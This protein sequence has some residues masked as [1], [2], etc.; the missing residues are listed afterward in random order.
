MAT[1]ATPSAAL[2]VKVSNKFAYVTEVAGVA[3]VDISNP[4]S[5]VIV[6]QF[7]TQG[8]AQGITLAGGNVYIAQGKAGLRLFPEAAASTTNNSIT[9]PSQLPDGI[10]D[11][12]EIVSPS[13]QPIRGILTVL[14][15]GATSS[16]GVTISNP[17]NIKTCKD[18]NSSAAPAALPAAATST[19]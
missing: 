15:G 6:G 13:A 17:N 5:P 1:L 14:N 10:Y 9:I 19:P 16:A 11:I 2:N 8:Y 12:T 18:S 4:T 3:V 7:G